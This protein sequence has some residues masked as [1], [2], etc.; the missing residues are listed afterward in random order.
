MKII[1]KTNGKTDSMDTAG[2]VPFERKTLLRCL[3]LPSRRAV[4]GHFSAAKQ[5]PLL[6][7]LVATMQVPN[8][9]Q[10]ELSSAYLTNKQF[11]SVFIFHRLG[12]GDEGPQNP[13]ALRICQV[14][15]ATSS[16]LPNPP[17]C[18]C[19]RALVPCKWLS[20]PSRRHPAVKVGHDKNDKNGH[21]SKIGYA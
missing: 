16:R 1:M 14:S 2:L 3:T 4:S 9:Q 19:W 17:T 20:C 18:E 8:H 11:G 5:K 15:P 10:Q 21:A 6:A 7:Q 12:P 13:K